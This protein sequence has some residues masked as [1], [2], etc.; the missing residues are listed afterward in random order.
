MDGNGQT[1]L[2]EAIAGLR[3]ANSGSIYLNN[4]EITNMTPR[5]ITERGLAHI[6][7]DRQKLGLVLDFSV[8]DNAVLQTYYQEPFSKYKMLKYDKIKALAEPIV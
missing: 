1:E 3:K 7:Q 6:P 4:K 8:G 2:I 5:K